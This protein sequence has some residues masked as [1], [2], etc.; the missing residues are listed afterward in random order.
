[1]GD[2]QPN[3]APGETTDAQ[4]AAYI[5][6]LPELMRTSNAQILPN[7]QAQLEASRIV[8][9]A[10]AKLQREIYEGGGRDLN[11]LG[12]EIARENALAQA[13]TERQV[14]AG[15]GRELIKEADLAARLADPEFYRV[16][17]LQTK[18]LAEM[19]QPVSGGEIEA[20]TRGLN[21]RDAGMGVLNVPSATKVVSGAMTYGES[22][23]N[24]LGH[25]LELATGMQP[26]GVDVFGQATGR[27]GTL[28]PGD[29]KFIGARTSAGDQAMQ[30]SNSFLQQTGENS[31]LETNLRSRKKD[32]F[33]TNFGKFSSAFA[34][35]GRG[36]AGTSG[37]KP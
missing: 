10:Y 16:R 7:E 27:L 15:P 30:M 35:L 21:Q 12:A 13:E 6:H 37:F 26:K 17:D 2:R 19:F 36:W 1:M 29:N 8:S 3:P 9:P 11:R 14:L 34:D 18:G 33:L 4:L 20:I 25:A 5:K 32:G 28:N 23:R 31:R 22:A 24:R